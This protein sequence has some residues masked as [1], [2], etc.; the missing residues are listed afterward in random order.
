M[1]LYTK[2]I[3][4]CL[5]LL[6]FGLHLYPQPLIYTPNK[7]IKDINNPNISSEAKIQ[8]INL[9]LTKDLRLSSLECVELL[10]YISQNADNQKLVSSLIELITSRGLFTCEY[11]S[12]VDKAIQPLL[13]QYSAN[14]EKFDVYL[15]LLTRI[16]YYCQGFESSHGTK[17]NILYHYI[18]ERNSESL[19]FYYLKNKKIAYILDKYSDNLL[20]VNFA[21]YEYLAD[22]MIKTEN[23]GL[24]LQLINFSRIPIFKYY[25]NKDQISKLIPLLYE[26]DENIKEAVSSLLKEILHLQKSADLTSVLGKNWKDFNFAAY[27]ASIIKDDSRKVAERNKAS[28]HL[29]YLAIFHDKSGKNEFVQLKELLK[30]KNLIGEVKKE[31]YFWFI[32]VAIG[33]ENPDVSKEVFDLILGDTESLDDFTVWYACYAYP[34]QKNKIYNESYVEIADKLHN[35]LQRRMKQNPNTMIISSFKLLSYKPKQTAELLLKF[36][37]SKTIT[38]KDDEI[39]EAFST[40]E[41]LTGKDYG[42]DLA[43]W[44]KAISEMPED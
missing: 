35:D 10:N 16:Y 30:G 7:L 39:K 41:K 42:T 5:I 1:K 13:D 22:K 19:L 29:S 36:L 38:A 34:Y 4:I 14:P 15:N 21:G 28:W 43:A 37:A 8:R 3:S 23:K 44:E 12:D 6:I 25:F 27:L 11:L 20:R 17:A 26:D 32:Y 2:I 31:V 24:K 18:V 40:L 9:F 33:T